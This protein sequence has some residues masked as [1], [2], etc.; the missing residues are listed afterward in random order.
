MVN[1]KRRVS[2][3]VYNI[4]QNESKLQ[5]YMHGQ[6]IRVMHGRVRTQEMDDVPKIKNVWCGRHVGRQLTRSPLNDL[7]ELSSQAKL[8]MGARGSM[9]GWMSLMINGRHRMQGPLIVII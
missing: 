2:S 8:R 1:Y 9:D 7:M 4:L 3:Y 6:I 5:V